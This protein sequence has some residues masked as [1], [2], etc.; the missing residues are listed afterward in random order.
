M[1]R[2]PGH[3]SGPYIRT[4]WALLDEADALDLSALALGVLTAATLATARAGRDG[5]FTLRE[6][7]R[8]LSMQAARKC[9]VELEG[10]G[11]VSQ[12]DRHTWAIVGYAE[13]QLTEA[14]WAKR[15]EDARARQATK[16][17]LD[18]ARGGRRDDRPS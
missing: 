14:A 8:G 5:I 11:Y 15:R 12:I 4:H 16:R 3:R 17:A 10:H 6:V 13:D 1:T 18:A 7:T 2:G 9:L